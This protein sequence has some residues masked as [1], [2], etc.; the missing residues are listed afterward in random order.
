MANKFHEFDETSL[1]GARIG[2]G[3]G[4]GLSTGLQMLA[5]QK[6]QQI[7]QRNQQKEAATGLEALGYTPDQAQK[8]SQFQ[9]DTIRAIAQEKVKAGSRQLSAAP[10]LKT[11]IPELSDKESQDIG[12]LTPAIQ[13]L[14]YKN[15]LEAL[16]A[17]PN[18]IKE[19][20][21]MQSGIPQAQEVQEIQPAQ[22][23]ILPPTEKALVATMT[24]KRLTPTERIEQGRQQAAQ[25]KEQQIRQ[26]E[27]NKETQKYYDNLVNLNDAA[28]F[29]EP[30]LKKMEHLV[31][32]KG[33]LPISSVY[34]LFS[35][36]EDIRPEAGAQAGG[37]TG[38]LIGGLLGSAGGPS[39]T[40]LGAAKGA[41]VGAGLGAL[42]KPLAV[43]LKSA[44]RL[45][46]PNT[47][48]FEKLSADFVRGAKLWFGSKLTD[49]D[50]KA[51]LATI[52][53]L[54][55]TDKGKLDIIH[56][57]RD[58]NKITK[59]RYRAAKQ[60]IREN[61]GDR[62][63]NF[64]LLIE[65]RAKKELDRLSLSIDE[66]IQRGLKDFEDLTRN[67]LESRAGII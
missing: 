7:N 67:Y 56:T 32:S 54:A 36:L 31:K 59:A 13:A 10:G 40:V 8:I 63:Q 37:V 14:Y 4:Q 28:D 48:E 43:L 3:I 42:A 38:G 66:R 52:P 64:Q 25:K 9:P 16:G 29:E 60:L 33:G 47:E 24:T 35:S 49:A 55:N 1:P 21:R 30:H 57:K 2:T 5:Q 41:S 22:S 58:L 45:T 15:Y 39:G 6:L 62:P 12:A 34:N 11:I 50:L 51:Y 17:N 27:V 26:K 46:S 61:H 65:E 18:Q 20:E 44:Q 23:Q 19:I 53:T